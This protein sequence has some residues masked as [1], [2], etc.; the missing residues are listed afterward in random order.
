MHA[1]KL[2][3][4]NDLDSREILFAMTARGIGNLGF[5]IDWRMKIQNQTRLSLPTCKFNTC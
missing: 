2:F 3:T 1:V 5:L 4:T